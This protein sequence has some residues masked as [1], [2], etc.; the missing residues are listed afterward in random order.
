M[1]KESSLHP[2]CRAGEA[3]GSGIGDPFILQIVLYVGIY[4][5]SGRGKPLPYAFNAML[6]ILALCGSFSKGSKRDI[7]FAADLTGSGFPPH[8]RFTLF[9][10]MG[11]RSQF[12]YKSVSPSKETIPAAAMPSSPCTKDKAHPFSQMIPSRRTLRGSNSRLRARS[13]PALKPTG[14]NSLPDR[15]NPFLFAFQTKNRNH[16]FS[17]MIPLWRTLRDSNP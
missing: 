1:E 3:R 12:L 9:R 15:S 2:A 6:F 7:H 13:G 11:C 8:Q 17:Q 5:E 10:F 14:L 4:G 16:P